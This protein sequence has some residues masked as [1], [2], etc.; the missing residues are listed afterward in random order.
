MFPEAK[1]A[2]Q[3]PTDG[4]DNCLHLLLAPGR[5]SGVTLPVTGLT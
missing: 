5:L 4:A 2:P 3:G 1:H